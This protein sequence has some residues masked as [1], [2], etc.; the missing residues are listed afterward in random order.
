MDSQQTPHWTRNLPK[1]EGFYWYREK[2]SVPEVVF[3]EQDMQWVMK[4]GTDVPMGAD[5]AHKIEGE[6]W[7]VAVFPP[8]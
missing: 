8:K 5:M 2:G 4:A 3:W 6:F 1:E 7:S